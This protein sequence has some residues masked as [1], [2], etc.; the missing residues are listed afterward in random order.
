MAMGAF[1]RYSE[2]QRASLLAT[3]GPKLQRKGLGLVA[4][5]ILPV[6]A[7]GAII[8]ISYCVLLVRSCFSKPAITDGKAWTPDLPSPEASCFFTEN[9][10]EVPRWDYCFA[11]IDDTRQDGVGEAMAATIAR[12]FCRGNESMVLRFGSRTEARRRV[13]R[14]TTQNMPAD[15]DECIDY[16]NIGHIVEA[17]IAEIPQDED[18]DE[19]T[20]EE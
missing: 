4:E 17:Y 1:R 18:S 15:C 7:M 8:L 2:L 11:V 13:L 9:G 10:T 6:A 3:W 5:V 16:H 19:D 20:E 14:W 12:S